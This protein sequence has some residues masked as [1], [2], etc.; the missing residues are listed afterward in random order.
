MAEN[1][2]GQTLSVD[3]WAVIL[4]LLAAIVVKM[5]FSPHVP[6]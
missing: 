6:W 1:K 5:G 4:A 3:W 2:G